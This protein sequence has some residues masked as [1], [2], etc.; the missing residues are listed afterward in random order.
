M[1]IK[2]ENSLYVCANLRV[3]NLS[4][5]NI[6]RLYSCVLSQ[7]GPAVMDRTVAKKW[8]WNF[9]CGF[10]KKRQINHRIAHVIGLK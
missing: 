1:E 10:L 5:I 3:K 2:T 8:V 4:N 9:G 6:A 7:L